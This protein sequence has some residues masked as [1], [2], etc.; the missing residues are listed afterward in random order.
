M[1]IPVILGSFA[2]PIP[3][4]PQTH[5]GTNLTFSYCNMSFIEKNLT[6][7]YTFVVH[8]LLSKNKSLSHSKT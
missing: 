2:L 7:V 3:T 6:V 1:Y 5:A 8:A 4:H